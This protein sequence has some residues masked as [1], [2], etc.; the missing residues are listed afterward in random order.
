MWSHYVAQAGLKL[1]GSSDPPALASQS[2]G[3]TGLKSGHGLSGFFAQGSHKA[4]FKGSTP[5]IP[6]TREAE[7]GELLEPRRQRLQQVQIKPLHSSLGKRARLHLKIYIRSLAVAQ[8]KFAVARSQLTATSTS[9]VSNENI[10][11]K[12]SKYALKKLSGLDSEPQLKNMGSCCVAQTDLKLLGSSNPLVSASQSARITDGVSLAQ[13]GVQWCDLAHCSLCLPGSSDSP[14]SSFRVAGI[15]ETGFHHVGQADLELLTSGD[16]FTSAS[17]SAGITGMSH[18]A[19]PPSLLFN[20]KS[21]EGQAWRLTPVILAFW[22]AKAGGSP[23]LHNLGSLQHL[24]PG[25]KQSAASAFQSLALSP[26]LASSGVILAHC[27]FCLPGS[28][29]S[30][31]SASRVAGITGSHHHARLNFPSQHGETPVFTKNTNTSRAWWYVPVV[32]ATQ[33]AEAGESLEPENRIESC[34]AARLKCSGVISTHCKL[35]LPASSDSPAS[36]SRVA[37]TTGGHHHAQLIFRQG[38]TVGQAGLE[39]LA[40]SDPPALASQ[41][42]CSVARLECSGEILAHCNLCLPGS[43]DSPASASRVAGL[44]VAGITGTCHHTWI[45]FYIFSRDRVSPCWSGWSQ[46]PDLQVI[47]PPLP[48]KV[49]G[50]QA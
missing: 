28:S 46:T 14:I 9:Q 29:D 4:E 3:I 37:G 7:A 10:L 13:A 30:P 39:L 43:S 35:C 42:S 20:L 47:H 50:L 1:L 36:A 49:L 45:I 16:S 21:I 26:R 34:S 22:E 31:A 2:S 38:F 24:P 25:F 48:P 41:E 5:V 15:T 23:E 33:E 6:A 17:Q 32:P 44:Q 18:R 11:I 8:A 40:S 12:E 27:K 19:W